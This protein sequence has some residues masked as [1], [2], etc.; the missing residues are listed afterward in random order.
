LLKLKKK[1]KSKIEAHRLFEV[2]MHTLKKLFVVH[3]GYIGRRG[4][5]WKEKEGER[6]RELEVKRVVK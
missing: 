2:Y 4:R 5:K 1:K 3:I 6:E